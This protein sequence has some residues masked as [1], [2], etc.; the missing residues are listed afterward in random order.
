MLEAAATVFAERGYRGASQSQIA[1][2]AGVAKSL[3]YQHFASKQELYAELMGREASSLGSYLR[4]AAFRSDEPEDRMRLFVVAF[5]TYLDQ[6]PIATRLLF[7][8]ADSDPVIARAELAARAELVGV[9]VDLLR[10]DGDFLAGDPDRDR[11]TSVFSE[12]VLTSLNGVAAW[13]RTRPQAT[14][15]ELVQRSMQLLW[16]GLSELRTSA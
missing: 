13:A 5:F 15:D 4:E 9:V 7:R 14:Q 11:A 16:P 10:S 1:R 3:L 2:R 8:D 12:L 6:R